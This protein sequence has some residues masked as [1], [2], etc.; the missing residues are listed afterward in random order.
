MAWFAD[1]GLLGNYVFYR[2][3]VGQ[4]TGLLLP[5][6]LW[7]RR[8]NKDQNKGG[9]RGSGTEPSLGVPLLPLASETRHPFQMHHS[10]TVTLLMGCAGELR[11][12]QECSP[13]TASSSLTWMLGRTLPFVV[14]CHSHGHCLLPWLQKAN[15]QETVCGKK[16]CLAYAKLYNW[17]NSLCICPFLDIYFFLYC[18]NSTFS[19]SL[20]FR[21]RKNSPCGE[22]SSQL[23]ICSSWYW[24]C[25]RI[26]AYINYKLFVYTNSF[27]CK[28]CLVERCVYFDNGDSSYAP[29]GTVGKSHLWSVPN[30]QTF[31][32]PFRDISVGQLIPNTK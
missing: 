7:G 12:L 19:H 32:L 22:L 1:R 13:C 24:A 3:V 26:L 17:Q 16:N 2:A 23:F 11:V 28:Q 14:S 15:V 31:L 25:K 4:I 30:L 18:L 29:V 9:Q 27:I 10:S 20:T 21:I 6:M 8:P 5:L